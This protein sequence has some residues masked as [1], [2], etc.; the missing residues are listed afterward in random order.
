ML[1][2]NTINGTLGQN[3]WYTSNIVLTAAATDPASRVITPCSTTVNT[4]TAGVTVSCTATSAGGSS[5]SPSVTVKRDATP[6][7]ITAAVAPAP[8]ASG[9]HNSDVTVSYTCADALAGLAAGACPAAQ[10]FS[11]EGNAALPTITDLAGNKSVSGVSA[12]IDKSAPVVAVTGVTNGAT[13]IVGSVPAAACSTSDAL[14]GAATQAA[15]TVSGGGSDGLG[16]FTVTCSGGVAIAAGSYHNLALKRDGTVVAWDCEAQFNNGQCTVPAGLSGVVAISGG[17]AHSLALKNDGTI[18]SW[19]CVG[20]DVG[21]CTVPAGVSGATAI[22]AGGLHSVALTRLT[23]AGG[24]AGGAVVTADSSAAA[25]EALII[26][27]LDEML[28]LTLSVPLSRSMMEGAP[29]VTTSVSVSAPA[30]VTAPVVAEAPAVTTTQP[31]TTGD[32]GVA[33]VDATAPDTTAPD[34]T[35]QNQRLFL[36]IITNVAVLAGA[37]LGSPGGLALLAVVVL[38]VVG[39]VVRRRQ[40]N[41]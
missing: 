39:A 3:G 38:L 33:P 41:R 21:Q 6:P 12:R 40:R 9:W 25:N 5:T 26:T 32:A 20:A 24:A 1:A 34:T 29:V 27:P 37:A 4:D 7:T 28:A 18:V 35:E 19:G 17:F 14:S 10:T 2:A 22:S 36:P 8:N 11:A 23:P 13:Y 31:V 30:A 15:A 16:L